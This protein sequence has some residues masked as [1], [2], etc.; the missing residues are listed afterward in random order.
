MKYIIKLAI[1]ACLFTNCSKKTEVSGIV[2]SKHG[3]PV[4]NGTIIL[5]EADNAKAP[6]IDKTVTT[7]DNNGYYH[8]IFKNRLKKQ[9]WVRCQS[10]SGLALGVP[11]SN[12][13]TNYIILNTY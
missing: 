5:A 1:L 8:F 9:Y 10:D 2:Y 11:I 3:A 4:P 12:N 13:K 6:S 7:T